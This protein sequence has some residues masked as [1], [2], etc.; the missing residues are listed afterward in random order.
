MRG[1]DGRHW[2]PGKVTPLYM[3]III[4]AFAVP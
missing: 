1:R 2:F 3:P 4:D